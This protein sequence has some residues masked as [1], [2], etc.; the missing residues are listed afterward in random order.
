L[1]GAI[2]HIEKTN[3]K[4]STSAT[5][6][7]NVGEQRVNGFELGF[8]G[9]V[10]PAWKIY[11]GYVYQDAKLANAG[12]VNAAFNGNQFPNTAENSASLWTSYKLLPQLTL[13]GGL[14]YVDKVFGNPANTKYVPSYVRLDAYAEYEINKN[15]SLQLNVQNLTDKTY[16]DRAYSTHMVSVAPGRQVILTAN[17]KY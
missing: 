13:G 3:A 16:F 11:G 10:S 2:F 17:F 7:A 8:A 6:V 4:V 9:N 14:F 1:T 15:V 5:T 12:P